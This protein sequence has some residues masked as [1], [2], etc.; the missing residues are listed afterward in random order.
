MSDLVK[1]RLLKYGITGGICAVV[2][3]AY[4]LAQDIT[5]LPL[6]DVYRVL[7]DAFS[8]PGLLLLFG[9]VMVWLSNEGAMDGIGFVL[10][11]AIHL[12]IPTGALKHEKYGDYV[13]RK[14]GKNAQGYGFLLIV[15]TVC[16]AIALVF[17][18]LY[19]NVHGPI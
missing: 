19:M 18:A 9:G 16:L 15:G 1:T 5:N 7:C 4:T 12:L 3:V 6:V 13:A 8:I 14:R 11:R 2:A 17:L 10:S